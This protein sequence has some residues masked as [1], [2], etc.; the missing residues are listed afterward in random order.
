MQRK[1][2]WLSACQGCGFYNSDLAPGPGKAFDG[3][4][5]LR[6]KNFELV[7]DA[8]EKVRRV[9][10][11]KLLEI[12]AAKGWFL[13]AAARRG[14]AVTGVEPVSPDAEIARQLGFEV[15]EGLFPESPKDHG[16]YDI[17]VFNDVFEHIPDPIEAAR[18]AA[19]LLSAGGLLVIN[20]PSSRGVVFRAA[21][22][23]HKIGVSGPFERLWQKGLP[24][25]HMTYFSPENLK[26]LIE[27]HTPLKRR[28]SQPLLTID[29]EGLRQRID[30]SPTGLPGPLAFS[31]AWIASFAIPLL[32]S[33]IELSIFSNPDLSSK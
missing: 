13:E 4:E 8:V 9:G 16:P 7:L 19:G 12:G 23:L 32:P 15:E 21:S 1:L 31:A 18:A 11:A 29:R 14:A 33:D 17:I 20:I 6:R 26:A 25:P 5:A 3:I 22:V 30:S 2:S 28:A 27:K 10:G 24:S